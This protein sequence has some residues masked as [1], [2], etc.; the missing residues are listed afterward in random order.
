MSELHD[1]VA[2]LLAR[3]FGVGCSPV[4]P[5]TVGTAVAVPLVICTSWWNTTK[6][7]VVRSSTPAATADPVTGFDD[8][9]RVVGAI[10]TAERVTASSSIISRKVATWRSSSAETPANVSGS[11]G[12]K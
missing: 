5:G 7:S 1:R 10:A 6:C 4:A 2:V 12:R 11:D 8:G 3:G 9:E